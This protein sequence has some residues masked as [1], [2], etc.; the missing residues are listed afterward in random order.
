MEITWDRG[1]TK[2]VDTLDLARG[3]HRDDS[4]LDVYGGDAA[5]DNSLVGKR[6]T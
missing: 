2:T 6:V 1:S 4:N 5:S 3:T